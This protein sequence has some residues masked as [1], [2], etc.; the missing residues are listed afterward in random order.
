MPAAGVSL[1]ELLA[2]AERLW[3]SEF[4]EPWDNPGLALGDPAD[5]IHGVLVTVDVTPGVLDE[6]AGAG[7]DVVVSHHPALFAPPST[8][9]ADAWPGALLARAARA[10]TALFSAHTNADA[11]RGGVND[12]LAEAIGV[13][14][15]RPLDPAEHAAGGDAGIGRVGTLG[16]PTE[17]AELAGRLAATLPATVGGVLMQG[18]DSAQVRTVALCSGSGAD[19]LDHADVVSADCYLTSDLKHHQAL[20]IASAR[21]AGLHRPALLSISHWA[22]ES[23]WTRRAARALR[24]AL[25]IGVVVSAVRTDPWDRRLGIPERAA[26]E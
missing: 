15:T 13:Q 21:A 12:A 8:L 4:A 19:Y 2:V 18:R 10:G 26:G 25:G 7:C 24:E 14:E 9:R 1:G 5:L 16:E 22:G 3:P 23:L 11:A 6:A 20:D 17:L